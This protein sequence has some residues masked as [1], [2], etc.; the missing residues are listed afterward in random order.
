MFRLKPFILLPSLY[1]LIKM[2]SCSLGLF[3][4]FTLSVY[5]ETWMLGSTPVI[6]FLSLLLRNISCGYLQCIRSHPEVGACI[7]QLLLLNSPQIQLRYLVLR[8]EPFY[9]VIAVN[10]IVIECIYTLFIALCT[11]PCKNRNGR[12]PLPVF[13]LCSRQL[14]ALCPHCRTEAA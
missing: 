7:V 13:L 1:G 3:I 12:N 14:C 5:R 8:K 6:Y 10:V 4:R 2:T 9:R 11:P